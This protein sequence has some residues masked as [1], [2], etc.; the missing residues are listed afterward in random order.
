[1]DNNLKAHTK[2][3]NESI[4]L[5]MDVSE[6]EKYPMK[7]AMQSIELLSKSL[8]VQSPSKA[9]KL[10]DELHAYVEKNKEAFE[11]E[12]SQE[13]KEFKI[14]S[15]FIF[16]AMG[17]LQKYPDQTFERVNK[18]YGMEKFFDKI[19]EEKSIPQIEY[20]IV[21]EFELEINNLKELHEKYTKP[22]MLFTSVVFNEHLNHDHFVK[23]QKDTKPYKISKKIMTELFNEEKGNHDILPYFKGPEYFLSNFLFDELKK[24]NKPEKILPVVLIAENL[25]Q[26]YTEELENTKKDAKKNKPS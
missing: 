5:E 24:L 9:F 22:V 19:S 8:R 10:S 20:K 15:S 2:E 13:K 12:S 23:T 7:V 17:P 16:S 6:V 1:M 3:T 25:R 4:I 14:W 21:N 11:T 26:L 18:V